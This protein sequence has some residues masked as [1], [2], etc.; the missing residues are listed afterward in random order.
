[1]RDPLDKEEEGLNG[2]KPAVNELNCNTSYVA[3]AIHVHTV[4]SLQLMN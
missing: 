1:M 4:G 2:G 3:K